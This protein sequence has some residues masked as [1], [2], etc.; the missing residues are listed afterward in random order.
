M[1]EHEGGAVIVDVSI[2]TGAAA[3]KLQTSHEN[4]TLK[5]S[6]LFI[7]SNIPSRYSK[8]L[9]LRSVISSYLNANC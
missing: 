1:V 4:P 3:L 8:L 2:D 6:P 5:S 9:L 7:A